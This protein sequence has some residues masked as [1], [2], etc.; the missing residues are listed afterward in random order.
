MNKIQLSGII[1]DIKYSHN[2]QDIEYYKANLLVPR[3]NGKEDINPSRG[4]LQRLSS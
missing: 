1:K 4:T 3:D 2:I